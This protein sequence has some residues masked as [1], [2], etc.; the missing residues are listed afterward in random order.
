MLRR[1]GGGG[2]GGEG[3]NLS[4]TMTLGVKLLGWGSPL[5]GHVQ[6]HAQTIVGKINVITTLKFDPPPPLSAMIF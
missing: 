4:I 3:G 5:R 2:G 1:R 6:T